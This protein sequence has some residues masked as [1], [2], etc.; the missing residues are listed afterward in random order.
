[1]RIRSNMINIELEMVL[2][3]EGDGDGAE[4]QTQSVVA[5]NKNCRIN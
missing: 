5:N 1:M 3:V 4:E 2:A